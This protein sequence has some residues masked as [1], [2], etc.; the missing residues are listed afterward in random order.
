MRKLTLVIDEQT[1][2]RTVKNILKRELGLSASLISHLKYRPEGITR[3]GAQIRTPEKVFLGD[4]LCVDISDDPSDHR[5]ATAGAPLRILYEDEDLLLINKPAGMEMHPDSDQ[6][7]NPSV[8]DSVLHYLGAGSVFHPVSRLDIDTS[9]ILAVAKHRYGCDALRRLLHTEDYIREYLA[10]C[11]GVPPQLC[12]TVDSPVDGAAA[13]TDYSV[14]FHTET[15]ALVKLRL[16]TG[17]TH[18]IRIHMA[19]LGCPLLGD[20]RY[21]CPDGHISRT[22]LHSAFVSL[23][24]PVSKESLQ[25]FC[26]PP[27]DFLSAAESLDLP[28]NQLTEQSFL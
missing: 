21:G 26:P 1:H 18:Q 12:G 13:K 14:L 25:I 10:L 17:R 8:K 15:H 22:A 23:R 28:A 24:H 6:L 27:E 16:H 4:V 3:N 9:G 5:P 7:C 11:N 2:G 19:S 20:A